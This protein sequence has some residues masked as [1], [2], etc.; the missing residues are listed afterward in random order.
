MKKLWF[1]AVCLLFMFLAG[2][3][4][5]SEETAPFFKTPDYSLLTLKPEAKI[6]FGQFTENKKTAFSFITVPNEKVPSAKVRLEKDHLYFDTRTQEADGYKNVQINFN[7]LDPAK[8]AEQEFCLYVVVQGP[9]GG[10]GTFYYEGHSKTGK[11]YYKSLTVPFNGTKQTFAFD[12]FIPDDLRSIHLRYDFF[13]PGEYRLYESILKLEKIDPSLGEK[14]KP[15]LIFH[16]PFDGSADPAVALGEKKPIKDKKITFEAGING[17]AAR[18]VQGSGCNLEY[19]LK[20][21]LDPEQGTISAWVKPDWGKTDEERKL[22]SAYWR[23]I[24]SMPWENRTRIGSGAIWFW[25]YGTIFRGDTSDLLDSNITKACPRDDSWHHVVFSWDKYGSRIYLDGKTSGGGGDSLNRAQPL[26]P[27]RYSRMER[28]SFSVGTLQGRAFDGL[29]DDLKVYSAPISKEDVQKLFN[30]YK[31]CTF[32]PGDYYFRDD[33]KIVLNGKINCTA[34]KDI[35]LQIKLCDLEDKEIMKGYSITAKA[36]TQTPYSIPTAD[37]AP[38]TYK[39]VLLSGNEL[40]TSYQ[41]HVF[42]TAELSK[43][44]V[45]SENTSKN[46]RSPWVN[47]L[48]LKLIEKID[49]TA[50]SSDRITMIGNLATGELNGKKYLQ[51]EG[52]AGNRFAIH[53]SPLQKGKVYCFQ[54]DFPDDKKRT[55]DIIAQTSKRTGGG[56]YELQTGYSIGDEYPNTNKMI[57]Q[58][59]IYWA[60]DDDISLIFTTARTDLKE[61]GGGA[62]VGEIRIYEIEGDLPKANIHPANPVNGWTRPVGIYFEDPAINYDF[63]IDGGKIEYFEPMIKR[64]CDYMDYSGQNLLAYPLVWYNG[65]IGEKYMPR[66]HVPRFFEAYLTAFDKRG[67][68]FM[69]T[70]NQNNVDIDLPYI[71]R[72]GIKKGIYYDSP[73]SIHNTGTTHPGGWHGSPPNFNPLH[74][75]VKEMTLRYFDE[76]IAIGAKHPSFKGIIMHLPR[77]ALHSFGDIQAGYNDYMIKDFEKET[78]ITV[79][80]DKSDPK[81]GKL[82]Y[83]WLMKNAKDQ[84]I[85][86]RCKKL[87]EWYKVLAEKLRKARPDLKLGINAMRP[88]VYERSEIYGDDQKDYWGTVNREMGIDAKYYKDTPN[89]FIDQTLFPADYRWMEGRNEDVR[90]NLRKT[91]ERP[92]M[93]ESLLPA[94][95]PWIHMH[96]RYWESAM[97][98]TSRSNNVLRAPWLKEH[99]WRVS[100]INPAGFYSMRHYIMPLRYKDILG[101][102][103]GG[104][105]IGTYGMEDYLVPFAAAFR[106]LPAVPFKDVDGSTDM[107]KIRTF[108]K[109]NTTW[110]Y[111]VNTLEKPVRVEIGLNASSAVDLGRNFKASVHNNKMGITLKPYELRSFSAETADP[112]SAKVFSE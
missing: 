76:I 97:G 88:I 29:I 52:K 64:L 58:K 21:N 111:V 106:A 27:R 46:R 87:S 35:P 20:G 74:P 10:K 42:N 90:N 96:D 17:Q 33:Q 22:K 54:W 73:F 70:I 16:L 100:T 67:L 72:T 108:Q 24:L 8:M 12:Q 63:G 62:A 65:M 79:D 102:S 56:E 86:W 7:G 6:I 34:K 112:V 78:G 104:F 101:Y 57:T 109:E 51:T 32:V 53:L 80:V 92:G 93:Y 89:L 37:I 48:Q 5:F 25:I 9:A 4:S 59:C 49:P 83:D 103:K 50:I 61:G 110:F 105:L 85:E 84:W 107:V 38:G 41:I 3:F 77:H 36:G 45:K 82:Y 75:D 66:L 26:R 91:E 43:H 19:S 68:E 94:D 13:T 30:E 44:T 1:S 40:I 99:G 11:H 98:D 69:G 18:F 23:P 47:D 81:R 95:M 60:P 14:M 71:T 31:V 15:E 55:V 28:D 2:S 39:V